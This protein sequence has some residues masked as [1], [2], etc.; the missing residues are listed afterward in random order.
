LDRHYVLLSYV[1]K[2]NK[3]IGPFFTVFNHV[4]TGPYRRACL[5]MSLLLVRGVSPLRFRA[6]AAAELFA[7]SALRS[8]SSSTLRLAI[9]RRDDLRELAVM[10]E[11]L[12]F[13]LFPATLSCIPQNERP[14]RRQC[15]LRACALTRRRRA[16]ATETSS[17][18]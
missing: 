18:M 15:F 14:Y 13:G 6:F 1:A 4:H 5:D 9:R 3:N 10:A 12:V 17:Q 7:A 11:V 2:K 8:L 16:C